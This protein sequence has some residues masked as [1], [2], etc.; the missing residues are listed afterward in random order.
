MGLEGQVEEGQ[1]FSKHQ[2][3]L[4]IMAGCHMAKAS[5]ASSLEEA[6]ENI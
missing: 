6:S 1:I 4:A 5:P 3:T 2:V